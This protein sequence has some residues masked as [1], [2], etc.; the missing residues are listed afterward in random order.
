MVDPGFRVEVSPR[1]GQNIVICR[2]GFVKVDTIENQ[3]PGCAMALVVFAGVGGDANR[4]SGCDVNHPATRVCSTGYNP[5]CFE[6]APSY[7]MEPESKLSRAFAEQA[8]VA[9][10]C[11]VRTFHAR[12]L[13]AA[14][15]IFPDVATSV[16]PQEGTDRPVRL[17]FQQA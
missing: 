12:R 10:S 2:N 14:H 17:V 16:P 1:D 4:S 3:Q 6:G 11:I 9:R 13:S 8:D 15:G 5:G 7:F